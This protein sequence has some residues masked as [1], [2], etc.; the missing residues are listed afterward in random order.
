M[1]IIICNRCDRRI[2]TDLEETDF[3]GGFEVCLPCADKVHE[4]YNELIKI[5][6]ELKRSQLDR[7]IGEYHE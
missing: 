7:F 4:A 1:S 3:V 6:A 5:N 2:D